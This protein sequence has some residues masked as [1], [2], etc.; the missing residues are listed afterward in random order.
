MSLSIYDGSNWRT[1]VAVSIYDGSA[2]RTA[3]GVWI[4]DGSAWRLAFTDGNISG[5]YGRDFDGDPTAGN[6]RI[7]W[8]ES[9]DTS[10]FTVDIYADFAG[11]TSYTTEIATGVDPTSGTPYDAYLDGMSGF[12]SLDVTNVRVRLLNGADVLTT[13]T[14]AG[15]YAVE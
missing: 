14:M 1:A 15:P 2:W 7:R 8:T 6:L 9:G 12:T 5:L 11:G 4:Y 3:K 10:A 13:L